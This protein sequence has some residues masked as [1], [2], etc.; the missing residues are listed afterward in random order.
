MSE[1][2]WAK[3][4]YSAGIIGILVGSILL[5]LRKKAAAY[6]Y[7]VSL[8]GF[9]IHRIWVFG[10]SDRADEAPWTLFLPMLI[11]ISAIWIARL[12]SIKRWIN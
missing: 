6:F 3:L 2:F 7:M 11:I 10:F 4:S 12:G 9:I 5:V 1:P 8:V